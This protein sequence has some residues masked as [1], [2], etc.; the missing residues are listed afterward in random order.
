MPRW[1]EEGPAP[2]ATSLK[3]AEAVSGLRLAF[4]IGSRCLKLRA[5]DRVPL[6]HKDVAVILGYD[7]DVPGSA[8]NAWPD[9]VRSAVRI[10][11]R[12]V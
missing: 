9:E 5:F 4:R 3:L 8:V 6:P 2:S 1:I 12:Q 10:P 11:C 7:L